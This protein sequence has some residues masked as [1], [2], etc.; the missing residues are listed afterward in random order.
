[1]S[2]QS[3][4]AIKSTLV[5]PDGAKIHYEIHGKQDGIPVLLLARGGMRSS[6]KMW[7]DPRNVWNPLT[8]LSPDKYR[9]VAMDQR[10]S[11][12][13]QRLPDD[14]DIGWKTFRD[15]QI[16][17]LDH[18]GIERCHILGSCIGPSYA[19]QLLRDHPERFDRAVLMQ[20]IGLNVH[21]TEPV[22]WEGTNM[23]CEKRHWFGD[24]A[25]EMQKAN[26]GSQWALDRLHGN[27]FG[28]GRMDFVFSVTR[29]DVRNKIPHR[30]LL[31][32]GRDIFHPAE[33]TRE[34]ARIAGPR[35]SALIEEWRDVGPEKLA[36]AERA[37]DEFLSDGRGLVPA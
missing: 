28:P 33:T 18:I 9:L 7:S 31:L 27:M 26:L 8:R 14:H 4:R 35:R 23:G 16:A 32:C 17:L 1:M 13:D 25:A 34:I 22:K 24:W 6:V 20:P 36:A 19:L 37:I 15:D 30:L 3:R 11:N 5:R 29:D 2:A 12:L 10:M 21:T